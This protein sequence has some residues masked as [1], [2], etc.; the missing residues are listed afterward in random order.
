MICIVM[1]Q[2]YKRISRKNDVKNPKTTVKRRFGSASHRIK[3]R[4][5]L[6]ARFGEIPKPTVK[7][8]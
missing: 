2:K 6:Y 3:V 8:G 4:E 1:T 7:S 5:R